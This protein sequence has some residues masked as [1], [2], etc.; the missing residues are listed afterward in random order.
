MK[1]KKSITRFF[2]KY[3]QAAQ[4]LQ[5]RHIPR[6]GPPYAFSEMTI[7]CSSRSEADPPS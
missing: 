2:R 1:N 4:N 5:F 7:S 3:R 6:G